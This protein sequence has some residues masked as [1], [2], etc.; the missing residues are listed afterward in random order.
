MS[1]PESAEPRIYSVG[2]VMAGLRTLLED[3]VGRLWISGELSN[4]HHAR[5][6][7]TYFTLKDD[8]GQLR[9]ALFRSA[10]KRLRFELEDGMEVVVYGDVTV[11]EPRGDLQ[12]V[13]REVEPRGQGALQLAFD[14]LRSRLEA[15]GLFDSERKRALPTLPSRVG[16]VTSPTGAAI[17]DV[18]EVTGRR[19]P[20]ASI[21]IAATRVQGMGAD[22]EIAA[23]LDAMATQSDVDVILLVRGGGS[24]EDLQA[25]NSEAVARAIVRSPVPVISGVGHEVD[26]TIADLAADARAATPSVAAEMGVPDRADL[27][28]QLIRDWQR[29]KSA[30]AG[31][32]QRSCQGLEKERAALRALSPSARLAVQR[33]RFDAAG[34]AL[35]RVMSANAQQARLR[36]SALAGRLDSLSPLGVLDR[37]Y[38]LVRRERDGVILRSADQAEPGERLSIRLA[39]AEL[40]AVVE[41]VVA[42]PRVQKPL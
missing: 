18:L 22:L 24:L 10:A 13:A 15:E 8:T 19:Y 34:R 1:E 36:L 30:L 27:Q 31:I 4:V 16:V 20:T 37:G 12:L 25:F 29:L 23:A 26:V 7:H 41:Q 11:Y 40:K 6:G 33:A 38:G 9:A 17:R 14:Q 21:V 32:L 5:S 3:R 39:E 42:L 28:R 2:Q 35:G